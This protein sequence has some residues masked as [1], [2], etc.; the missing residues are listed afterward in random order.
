VLWTDAAVRQSVS[1][2]RTGRF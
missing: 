2:L 1:F